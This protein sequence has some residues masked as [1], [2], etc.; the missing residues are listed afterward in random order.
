MYFDPMYFVFAV[1]PL[2]FGLWAQWKVKS[3][4][5]KYSNVANSTGYTG[6][7][8]ARRLLDSQGLRHVSV[9]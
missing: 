4:F 6:A 1:P 3:A 5:G 9:E 2:L 7:D 8:I